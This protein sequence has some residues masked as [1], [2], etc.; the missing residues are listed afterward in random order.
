MPS[1]EHCFRL[2]II[3]ILQNEEEEEEEI[4]TMRCS[5]LLLSDFVCEGVKAI[6][7]FFF[8]FF[9]VFVAFFFPL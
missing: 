1:L 8:F 6:L 9:V 4:E 2:K 5:L 3:I 7:H